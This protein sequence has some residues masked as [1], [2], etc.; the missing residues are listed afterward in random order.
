MR[1]G[2][3]TIIDRELLS[4]RTGGICL[5]ATSQPNCFL[6]Q[7]IDCV[8]VS[9]NCQVAICIDP[10]HDRVMESLGHEQRFNAAPHAPYGDQTNK[11]SV[12][13]YNF[14]GIVLGRLLVTLY[15]EMQKEQTEGRQS[16]N[17]TDSTVDVRIDLRTH[18]SAWLVAFRPIRNN[19][20]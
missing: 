20:T 7:H 16:D 8:P 1:V 13:N 2:C 3:R 18:M 14:T 9:G 17:S 5:H 12:S 10:M 11:S 6:K 19:E 15:E 4:G